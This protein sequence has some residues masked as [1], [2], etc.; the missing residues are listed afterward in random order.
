MLARE[1]RRDARYTCVIDK[2]M[3]EVCEG[4]QMRNVD[5]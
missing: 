5:Y 3:K 2:D 4:R 1:R